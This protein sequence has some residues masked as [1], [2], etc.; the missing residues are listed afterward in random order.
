MNNRQA[1]PVHGESRRKSNRAFWR[2][3]PGFAVFGL[4]FGVWQVLLTDLSRELD[5]S[6]GPLG[7]AISAGFVAS[8]PLMIVA[9][10]V[11]DRWGQRR[12]AAGSAALL[13]SVFAGF[14]FVPSY[15][16]LIVLLVAFF[17][18]SGVF[19]VVIN[20]AAM[21]LEQRSA[22]GV[23]PLFHAG[24]SGGAAAGALGAGGLLA[25]GVE[26]RLIYLGVG[27]LVWIVGASL[28][29]DPFLGAQ[30]VA[31]SGGRRSGLELFRMRALMV[32][33]LITGMAFLLEGIMETWSVVYLRASLE[34][35]AI[36][37]ALG[38]AIFHLAMMAGRL[39]TA[40]LVVRWG[41]IDSLRIAG[42]VAAI[43]ML[44]ALATVRE[45]LILTGFLIVGLALSAVAPIAFSLA[46]D[47]APGR[48]GE[49]SAV[50]TTIGY[51]G[52]LIGPALLGGLAEVSGLRTAL[53]MAAVAGVS[54]ALLARSI[55]IS[56]VPIHRR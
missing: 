24:F 17:G 39:G 20:A 37:G 36:V 47:L 13:G 50:L 43:G 41:R 28:W 1:V 29:F 40:A 26:F 27:A 8:F 16:I 51:S 23:L 12:V 19:D 46:G 32:V 35:T 38:G 30:A 15:L 34:M 53:L 55:Q 2:L 48:T 3:L 11:A 18:A 45:P 56:G 52:F 42:S 10:A 5:L 4:L 54:I 33:A 31:R 25:V 22:H 49:A 14:A 6:P 7:L 9:G 44:C 21:T